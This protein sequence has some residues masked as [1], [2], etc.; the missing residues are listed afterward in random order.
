[1]DHIRAPVRFAME[2]IEFLV[3]MI[4]FLDVLR[5]G[6]FL[7][8][9]VL[10]ACNTA[11]SSGELVKRSAC[12]KWTVGAISVICPRLLMGVSLN[13]DWKI[14]ILMDNLPSRF[15]ER[16]ILKRWEMPLIE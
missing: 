5:F 12:R 2:N 16:D 1:M 8:R 7:P 14:D 4:R 3:R 9:I 6:I 13:N 11:Y 15:D 10:K